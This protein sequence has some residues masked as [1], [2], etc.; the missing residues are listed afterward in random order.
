[1]LH[2]EFAVLNVCGGM[3]MVMMQITNSAFELNFMSRHV[4]IKVC[5]H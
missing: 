4:G 3:V 1:M 2:E 5:L